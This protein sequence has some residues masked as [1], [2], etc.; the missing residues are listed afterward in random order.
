MTIR[1]SATI[2]ALISALALTATFSLS[3]CAAEA[4]APPASDDFV[5]ELEINSG[6][7]NFNDDGFVENWGELPMDWPTDIPLHS[8]KITDSSYGETPDGKSWQVDIFPD[9]LDAEYEA[10]RQTL[11]GAGFAEESWESTSGGT[12]GVFLTDTHRIVVS[13]A[14]SVW[15]DDVVRYE[16]EPL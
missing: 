13:S 10:A 4:A 15:G 9:D 3:G 14:V 8:E 1:K 11:N 7:D 16:V 5:Q 2:T 6:D 12:E